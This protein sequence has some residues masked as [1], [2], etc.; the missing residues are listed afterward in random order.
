MMEETTALMINPV[1]GNKF[2]FELR[3]CDPSSSKIRVVVI[4]PVDNSYDC[5]CNRF[6]MNGILCHHILK[7]MVHTNVQVI[8]EKYLLYRWSEEATIRP[9]RSNVFGSDVPETNTLRYNDLCIRMCTLASDACF[10]PETYKIVTGGVDDLSNLVWKWRLSGGVLESA[11]PNEEVV[12]CSSAKNPPKSAK[13]GR[14]KDKENR[15]KPLV[16]IRQEKAQQ[17]GKKKGLCSYC[18][19]D[20]HDKRNCPYL[21][22]ERQRQ[23]VELERVRRQTELTL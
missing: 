7:V 13:K 10:G 20:W 21:A 22:L 16:E 1:E 8:P 17:K 5:S 6:H 4:D 14:P 15:K 19:E 3:R 12:G 18:K 2:K 11:A 9:A 23:K